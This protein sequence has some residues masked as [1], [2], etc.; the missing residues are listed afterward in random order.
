MGVRVAGA[1]DIEAGQRELTLATQQV[2]P[3]IKLRPC[4]K[5]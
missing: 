5:T 3:E 1:Q 2:K 4:L